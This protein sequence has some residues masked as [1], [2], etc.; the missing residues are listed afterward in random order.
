MTDEPII[1][2]VTCSCQMKQV[3]VMPMRLSGIRGVIENCVVYDP[4]KPD[5]TFSDKCKTC[6]YGVSGCNFT[7]NTIVK[8]CTLTLESVKE[9]EES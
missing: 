2:D 1:V 4:N 7:K 8:M 9:Q 5:D 6:K 3:K